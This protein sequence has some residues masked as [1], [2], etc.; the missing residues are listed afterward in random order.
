MGTWEPLQREDFSRVAPDCLTNQ[1]IPA[2]KSPGFSGKNFRKSFSPGISL[3]PIF[4]RRRDCSSSSLQAVQHGNYP[5]FRGTRKFRP[6][7]F[8]MT[9]TEAINIFLHKSIMEGGL[10]FAVRQPR[11]VARFRLRF[12]NP[13]YYCLSGMGLPNFM[14]CFVPKVRRITV[15]TYFLMSRSLSTDVKNLKASV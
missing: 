11:Y 1:A 5:P 9:L 15:S 4:L 12:F 13:S 10:P 2:W 3:L 14:A 7:S 6:A 8:G